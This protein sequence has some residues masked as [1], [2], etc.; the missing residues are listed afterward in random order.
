MLSKN[1]IKYS[2]NFKTIEEAIEYRDIKVKEINGEFARL[3]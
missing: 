3:D 2:K 1:K